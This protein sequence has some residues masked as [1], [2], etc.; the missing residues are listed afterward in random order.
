MVFETKDPT[1]ELAVPAK[2]LARATPSKEPF[3]RFHSD[4]M[5]ALWGERGGGGT[6]QALALER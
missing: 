2:P 3:V 1:T 6:G 5:L 4:Y